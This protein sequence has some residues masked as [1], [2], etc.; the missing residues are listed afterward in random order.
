MPVLDNPRWERFAQLIAKGKPQ[1]EAYELAG[2]KRDD[3]AAS[4][5]SSYVKVRERVAELN[6][7]AAKRAEVSKA[8]VMERLM[9]NAQMSLGEVPVVTPGETEDQE[10]VEFRR[11]PGAA[12]Q[13]LQLLGKELGMFVDRSISASTTLEELLDRLDQGPDADEGSGEVGAAPEAED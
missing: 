9:R 2:Y 6:D 7:K 13:A 1:V 4:R 11:D 12:N 10:T 3:G 5:L 8:W